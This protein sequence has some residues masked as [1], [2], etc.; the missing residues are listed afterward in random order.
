MRNLSII[1]MVAIVSIAGCAIIAVA[2]YLI[3]RNADRHDK[4]S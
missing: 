3:D 2:I 4:K 1:Y